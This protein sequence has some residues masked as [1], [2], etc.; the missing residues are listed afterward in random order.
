VQ[1]DVNTYPGLTSNPANLRYNTDFGKIKFF[2]NDGVSNYNAMI[3]TVRQTVGGLTYQASYTWGH[4]LA[5]PSENTTDQY[6]IHSQ[7]TNANFDIRNRLSLLQVY[8]VPFSN[9]NRLLNNVLGGWSLSNVFIVQSGSPFTVADTSGAYDFNKDDVFYDIPVY[10]GTK[11]NFSHS[12]AQN[13]AINGTSV[14]GNNK[15]A[16]SAPPGIQEGGKQNTFYGPGYYDLDTG[17]S[18]KNQVPWFGGEKAF[19]TLRVEGINVLNHTNYGN[20]SGAYSNS[21]SLGL[22]TSALQHR[23]IQIGSRLE[24]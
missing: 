21:S 22:V 16:F 8:E 10:N 7:Y 12:D 3:A 18:K 20:P 2:R 11:R 1:T 23:I 15:T 4:A 24:F 5:D 19:L 13:S 6:D 17:F 14:F 9:S